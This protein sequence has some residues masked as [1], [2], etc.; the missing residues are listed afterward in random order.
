MSASLS[1]TSGER[2]DP[3]PETIGHDHFRIHASHRLPILIA[4]MAAMVMQM[5]DTTIAN[6][7]LPHMQAS[8]SATQDTVSWILTSY[9]L[10]SAVTLPATGWLVD[11]FGIKNLLL[12]SVTTFTLASALCG[13]AMNLG[14]MVTFRVIQGLAGAFLAP[15]AQTVMLDLSTPEE[16]PRM[17]TIFTQGVMIGPIM[18]PMLGG[19]LTEYFNWRWVFYVNVP[20]GIGCVLA[21]LAFMPKTPTRQRPFDFLGWALVTIAVSS[22][23]L[24][25][26]RGTSEDWFGSGEIFAYL[27]ISACAFWMA[28]VH[29]ATAEHPLFSRGLFK[30]R[31]FTSALIL[32]AFLG[33]VL[34]STMALLPALLQ[35]IFGYPVI[36]SG[37]LLAPRG[38]GM[39]LSMMVFG[40]Y[41]ARSD[42]R[43]MLTM[44]FTIMGASLLMMSRWSPDMPAG[45]S[46]LAGV[47]QGL[48]MSLSMVPL[49][50]IAFATLPGP[51]RTDA[52]GLSNLVRNLGASTG[53]AICT[54]LLG[55]NIQ[56]NH[57]EIG[58]H[59]TQ[60]LV[61][62]NLTQLT[63]YGGA[64][65]AVLRVMDGMVN[66]QAAMIGYLNDFLLM[67]LGCFV[68]IPLLM[69]MKRPKVAGP[70][71]TE[72][73]AESGH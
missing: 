27:V 43:L 67:G 54:V 42:P 69:L 29:I 31:N 1:A 48:G 4:V 46:V 30:D 14:Q 6:V 33:L 2:D 55:H 20:I 25:L 56:V 50:I 53:I 68:L 21:V 38:I 65:D 71:A 61:P 59:I 11:R 24:M 70:S 57:A 40:K 60:S 16:R 41:I 35:T 66:K 28:I 22:L 19:Y 5:L 37:L 8:L 39:L 45:P 15:I 51:L 17:M 44:G 49:N 63:A 32:N 72:A 73:M 23:Q 64:G 3:L 47:I 26:D 52:S 9:V 12:F 10:A 62:F 7:A 18:G 34:M 58:A 36:D 13:A